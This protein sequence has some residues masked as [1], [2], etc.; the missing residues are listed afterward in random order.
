MKR[1]VV[2]LI[3][4]LFAVSAFAGG[5]KECNLKT[6][7]KNVELTGTLSKVDEDKTVFRV[8]NSDQ[9]YTVCHKSK[10]AVLK[11]GN[12]G[13]ALR[14]KGKV[15]SCGEGQELMIESGQKI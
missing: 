8:A 4:V 10:A 3:V 7:A 15:V 13:S 9:T 11:L 2:T 5:G 1:M 12:D 14:V 6:G